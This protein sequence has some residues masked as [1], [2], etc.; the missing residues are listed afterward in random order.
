MNENNIT[1]KD[2]PVEQWAN[3]TTENVNAAKSQTQDASVE[4]NNSMESGA[5]ACQNGEMSVCQNGQMSVPN[6]QSG[7]NLAAE[8][9]DVADRLVA[10]GIDI[11]A[12][13]QNWL[14]VGFALADGLGEGGRDIYQQ[15]SALY[16]NYN[17]AQCDKQYDAC[18]K[19]HGHGVTVKTFFHMAKEAG[20]DIA[21]VARLYSH[22]PQKPQNGG[23]GEKGESSTGQM[24]SQSLIPEMPTFT[25]IIPLENWPK[26]FQK[27]QQIA[28]DRQ[29]ADM[30]TMG[31]ITAASACLPNYTGNY[32]RHLVFAC[33]YAF[34][35]APPASNKGSMS[36]ISA[37][38]KYIQESIRRANK[39]E[40]EEYEQKMAEY[41][42]QKGKKGQT[43]REPK[44]PPYRSLFISANSS[45]T[46]MYQALSD[47]HECGFTFESEGDAMAN[48][49]KSDFGDYSDGLRKAFHHEPICYSRRKDNERVDIK[50]PRWA[51]LLTGTPDQVGNLIPTADNGTFSRFLF[52]VLQRKLEWRDVFAEE[53]V[54]LDEEFEKMGKDLFVVYLKLTAR[55]EQLR[56]KFTSQQRQKFNRFFSELQDEQAAMLGDDI[57]ASVRRLG[58]I[59]FRIAMVL[60]AL[61]FIDTPE[62]DI[63]NIPE[64]I[65]DDRDFNIALSMVNKLIN[66]TSM[67]YSTMLRK[68]GAEDENDVSVKMNMR[69]KLLFDNLSVDFT[70]K[71]YVAAAEK[72]EIPEKSAQKII[73]RFINRYMVVVREKNGKYHKVKPGDK[74]V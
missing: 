74:S 60:T 30:L 45:S 39:A 7:Q 70:T 38:L 31:M 27:L 14:N 53:E 21:E 37:F 49:L 56:F 1:K 68:N 10:K 36:A 12:G 65:C 44:Q 57:V 22:S 18:L 51:I 9:K 55:K 2:F 6:C 24:T 64:V 62:I 8:V 23:S 26:T 20:V 35:V 4:P 66:H 5:A 59:A 69:D 13:Y 41:Q 17:Q 43:V 42:A 11:T 40:F 28:E 73:G 61:R 25:D 50:K 58:L 34:I 16:P 72:L 47:N 67:V 71:D 54:T 3:P 63:Q 52:Y 46:A 33:L 19:S 15:V 32:D 48:A 29:T